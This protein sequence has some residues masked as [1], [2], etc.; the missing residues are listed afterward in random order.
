MYNFFP[1]QAFSFNFLEKA[2]TL[3]FPITP[4]PKVSLFKFLL[5]VVGALRQYNFR[6]E[7]KYNLLYN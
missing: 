5:R 3:P 6:V 4:P 2:L 7:Q 1:L